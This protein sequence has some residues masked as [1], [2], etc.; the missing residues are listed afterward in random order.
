MGWERRRFR[1]Y[2]IPVKPE[3][4]IV[5]CTYFWAGFLDR[6]T[7]VPFLTPVVFVGRNLAVGDTDLLYFQDGFSY[8]RGVRYGESNGMGPVMFIQ[9]RES[10]IPDI[11]ELDEALDMI[12]ARSRLKGRRVGTRPRSQN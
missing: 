10:G 8:Q 12:L 4:L 9:R 11:F 2:V 1:P 6:E 7:R 5:G 3:V